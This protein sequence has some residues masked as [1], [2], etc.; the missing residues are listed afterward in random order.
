M[1]FRTGSHL[2][3][4]EDFRSS[5]NFLAPC[6]VGFVAQIHGDVPGPLAVPSAPGGAITSCEGVFASL[7]VARCSFMAA[8]AISAALAPWC[9]M[10]LHA[11]PARRIFSRGLGTSWYPFQGELTFWE[12]RSVC[13]VRNDHVFC[14]LVWFCGQPRVRTWSA[15]H[16]A[17]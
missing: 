15:G 12:K 8:S 13:C 2:A 17:L 1:L 10:H 14:F 7:L 5:S 3:Y 4:H 11:I 16:Y 9:S 6:F